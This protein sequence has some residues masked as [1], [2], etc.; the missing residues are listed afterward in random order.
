VA[1]T[2]LNRLRPASD[3]FAMHAW[4][5]WQRCH[6]ALNAA[7]GAIASPDAVFSSSVTMVLH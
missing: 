6:P 4:L 3:V 7:P 5:G 2:V 1:H